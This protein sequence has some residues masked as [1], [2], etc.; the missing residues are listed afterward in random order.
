MGGTV[1]KTEKFKEK[2]RKVIL[3]N[4]A[5]LEKRANKKRA[6]RVKEIE[7]RKNIHAEIDAA[8][9]EG[10]KI[11][12]QPSPVVKLNHKTKNMKEPITGFNPFSKAAQLGRKK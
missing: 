6:Q 7:E 10:R 12:F 11:G 2:Q 1:T 5:I 4:K 3:E 8:K 9:S